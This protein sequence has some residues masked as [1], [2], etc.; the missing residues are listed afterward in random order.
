MIKTTHL[1]K[2][3][4]IKDR[5]HDFENISAKKIGVKMAVFNSK[6]R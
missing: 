6:Q 4:P 2:I 5:C 1:A 3:R